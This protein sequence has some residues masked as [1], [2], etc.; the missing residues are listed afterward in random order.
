MGYKDKDRQRA[1]QRDWVRQKRVKGSTEGS[2][3]MGSTQQGSTSVTAGI[4]EPSVAIVERPVI[5]EPVKP[6]SHNPMM[7]GYV[8]PKERV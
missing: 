1:Y 4:Q 3:S 6:Q 7:V 2:T 5:D 8:P